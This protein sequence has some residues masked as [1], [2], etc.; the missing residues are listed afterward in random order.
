M[1]VWNH[2]PTREKLH[3][4]EE[5]KISR[6]ILILVLIGQKNNGYFTWEPTR[7]IVRISSLNIY[8][9]KKSGKNDEQQSEMLIYD[10]YTSI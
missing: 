5:I 9:R 4:T 1:P 7:V 10:K 6:T 3:D 8:P 2:A